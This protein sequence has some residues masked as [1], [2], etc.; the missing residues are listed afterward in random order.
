MEELVAGLGLSNRVVNRSI[1][2]AIEW[3]E[4]DPLTL[5]GLQAAHDGLMET[6]ATCDET[7]NDKILFDLV[8]AHASSLH[9]SSTK[10]EGDDLVLHRVLNEWWTCRTDLYRALWVVSHLI[11]STTIQEDIHPIH[12]DAEHDS[13]KVV[14]TT[15]L[16]TIHT[17]QYI[18]QHVLSTFGTRHGQRHHR[19]HLPD[20]R[21]SL[22]AATLDVIQ[23]DDDNT[24][25]DAAMD[26]VDPIHSHTISEHDNIQ[27]DENVTHMVVVS[28]NEPQE[29]DV[30]PHE[31]DEEEDECYFPMNPADW[32]AEEDELL[33]IALVPQ[34]REVAVPPK[35]GKNHPKRYNHPRFVLVAKEGWLVWVRRNHHHHGTKE[36]R[37]RCLVRLYP[38]CGTISLR[39]EQHIPPST[40]ANQQ[41]Q[42]GGNVTS[43]ET[44][45]FFQIISTNNNEDEESKKTIVCEPVF[46]GNTFHFQVLVRDRKGN[47]VT[48]ILGVDEVTGGGLAE[49]CDWVTLLTNTLAEAKQRNE[50]WYSTGTKRVQLPR[51]ETTRMTDK[52]NDD[53]NPNTINRLRTSV[54]VVNTATPTTTTV[55]ELI[56]A[57][58]IL[59]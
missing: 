51:H 5:E 4:M 55:Q 52:D 37:I 35:K 34:K 20:S 28:G 13:T 21:Y 10:N 30:N 38:V 22:L 50:V 24:E 9:R 26:P 58:D 12:D 17:C 36:E 44:V 39:L 57:M 11:V 2:R 33:D 1:G 53:H 3:L 49:G 7:D 47:Y 40:T 25:Y 56:S 45:A 54:V 14:R 29:K 59:E 6:T 43:E 18:L 23:S 8:E 41:Q 27:N 32:A 31:E 16:E 48:L 42:E 19:H 15:L 46:M